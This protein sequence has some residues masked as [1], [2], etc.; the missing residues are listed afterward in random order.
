MRIPTTPQGAVQCASHERT[1]AQQGGGGAFLLSQPHGL[2]RALPL[3]RQGAGSTSPSDATSASTTYGTSR[4]T[5]ENLRKVGEFLRR[6]FETLPSSPMISSTRI[7]P[8]TS[9][10][11]IRQ[12]GFLLGGS[13]ATRGISRRARRSRRPLEPGDAENRGFI[14]GERICPSVL[15]RSA[16]H[17]LHGGSLSCTGGLA[18]KGIENKRGIGCAA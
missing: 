14:H 5:G 7:R 3:Q 4:S 6:D 8:M 15:G 1:R 18:V 11:P 2:Q 16:P 17:Q 9:S 10:S 12:G 13:G